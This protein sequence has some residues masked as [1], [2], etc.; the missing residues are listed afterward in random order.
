MRIYVEPRFDFTKDVGEGGVKQVIGHVLPYLEALGCEFVDDR[1]HADVIWYH[2]AP[3]AQTRHWLSTRPNVAAVCSNHGL[4]WAEYDWDQGSLAANAEVIEGLRLAD[5]VTVPSEWVARAIHRG[6]SADVRVVY[7][8]VDMGEW[9]SDGS[10]EPSDYALYDKTRVDP[11]CDPSPVIALAARMPRQNFV[12]TG[13]PPTDLPNIL[14]LGRIPYEDARELTRGAGV[15]LAV[16]R[17][18]FGLATL[19][20]MAA[21]VPVVGYDY[22][23]QS[24]F[25]GAGGILVPPGDLDALGVAVTAALSRR[26]ELGATAR[27]VAATFTWERAARL[28]YQAFEDAIAVHRQPFRVTV[29]TTAYNAEATL[30]RTI[31][32]ALAALGPDDEY[33]VVDDASAD[34]TRQIAEAYGDRLTLIAREENGYLAQ[35]RND[36][37]ARA[38]GRYVTC[39][40]ADDELRPGAL[41]ALAGELD[42]DRT[43]QIGYGKLHFA[44]EDDTPEDYGYGPG[45][46]PWPP[47]FDAGAQ[48]EAT[49]FSPMPYSAM[50]R[51]PW[52]ER[53]GGWRTRCRTGED[54]DLWMRLISYGA[55]PRRVTEAKVLTYHTSNKSMSTTNRLPDWGKWYPWTKAAGYRSTPPWGVPAPPDPRAMSSSWPVSHHAEPVVSVIIPVGPGHERYVMDAVDSVAA[56][57]YRQWECIVVNDTGHDLGVRM[58]GWV[59]LIAMSDHGVAAA[60][61][62]GLRGTTAPY[63][64]FLDADDWLDRDALEHLVETAERNP[65]HAVVYPDYWLRHGVPAADGRTAWTYTP[66]P[67]PDWDCTKGALPGALY[68]VTAIYRRA[69]VEAVGGFDEA[70]PGWEDG[71]LQVALAYAGYCAARLPRRLYVYNVEQSS[72][73]RADNLAR[74]PEVLEWFRNKYAGRQSM[75]CGTCGGKSVRVTSPVMDGGNDAV[76]LSG[77]MT[78]VQYTGSASGSFTVK[79]AKSGAFY[80][81]GSGR[82]KAKAVL[83]EDLTFFDTSPEFNVL[84]DGSPQAPDAPPSLTVDGPPSGRRAAVA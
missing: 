50:I 84:R 42:K 78:E 21:G 70:A 62:A 82:H 79:G 36:A 33:I 57:T 29:I 60:R 32:S 27:E 48:M 16:T 54:L 75:A 24:E 22:G 53:A 37:L 14:K 18:T 66:D 59:S 13:D 15:Y 23:G 76:V 30:R 43:I 61:N 67:L 40:D 19:Q 51:R 17:E 56:Q 77:G 71:D 55:R 39:L 34:T 72:G 63:V 12:M 4:Y 44:R 31:D 74:E 26:S 2:A 58:P 25:V 20:A 81:F 9:A 38:R 10:V 52:L 73:R 28:Y 83:D 6:I 41:D 47:E 8:G 5:V 80:T 68:G 7:H 11:V 3:Y 46:S 35:A 1:E 69:A 64:V 45:E 49:N 65:G